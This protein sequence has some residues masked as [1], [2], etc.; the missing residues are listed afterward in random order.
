MAL[1]APKLDDRTFEQLVAEARARIPRYTPEWT[2]LNDAD[3]GMTLVKLQAWLTETI[4]WQLNRLPDLNY[5]KFLDL[6]HVQP[7]PAVAARTE[8]SFK[9]KKLSNPS[10]PLVVLVP[11]R[12]QVA[13]D[14]PDLT[15]ELV[16]ETDETLTA[17]NAALAAIVVPGED[18][19][20]RLATQYD[21]KKGETAIPNA[22]FPFG[23]QPDAGAACY[24]GFVLRPQRQD[25]V[26]YSLDRFPA[27]QLDLAVVLPRTGEPDARG[28]MLPG[29]EA[30]RCLFP[31]QVQ[32]AANGIEWHGFA[33]SQPDSQFL[34]AIDSEAWSKLD[35]TDETAA[36][37]RNG[38]IYLNAPVGLTLVTLVQLNRSF[39]ARLGLRKRP[40]NK[41]EL[42]EDLEDFLDPK[43]ISEA[44]WQALGVP[45]PDLEDVTV[46]LD[47]IRAEHQ[48]IDFNALTEER[49]QKAGYDAAPV[50][51]PM[52][53]FRARLTAKPGESPQVRRIVINT[54]AAT[55]AVTRV[56]EVVGDSD[57][58]PNQLMVLRRTPVLV[59]PATGK[60]T[61]TLV[62]KAP[63]ALGEI[64]DWTPV[65]D[66]FRQDAE[67]A[68]Y[69]LDPQTGAI[70]FGDGKHGQ[71]PVAGRQVIARSYRIGGGAIGNVGPGTVS[72]LKSAVREVDSV[73]NLEAAAGGQDAE[74]LSDVMLRAPHDLRARDRA[75]SAE[76]FGDLARQ[77]PGVP[78]QRAYA[79][80]ETRLDMTTDPTTYVPD[81]AGAVTVVILPDSKSDKPDPSPEQLDLVCAHLN[82]RR[83]ITTELYVTGPRYR[84][85]ASIDAEL[86]VSRQ[87]DLKA[88]KDGVEARLLAYFHPLRG[89]EDGRGWPFNQDAYFGNVYRHLLQAPGLLS[90]QC[91][92]MTPAWNR[93]VE[94]EPNAPCEDVLPIGENDLFYLHKDAIHLKVSY[95]DGR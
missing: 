93:D 89:G 34:E 22:F 72:K 43:L 4:L 15:Q 42:I 65:G 59:D 70:T 68:V 33:G 13:V 39:W 29:P 53:W 67:Q 14:D 49:W 91:L 12:T 6:L 45:H 62:V 9:L 36:L 40:Y 66:F 48:Q 52:T 41:G 32:Q 25:G 77:T 50:G 69:V 47:Q 73:T 83:L 1:P 92:T 61:L 10:D 95:D 75:V 37:T 8:L 54:I 38:H 26:D 85:I 24:L 7:R 30:L 81:S 90:V 27:E 17:L 84:T 63:G 19:K 31:W 80:A 58:R 21:E 23:E 76:D 28:V 5:V 57:G 2:N 94:E 71:I 46:L 51:L 20:L 60:S 78:I 74:P 79:L 86:L 82:A 35:E 56:D 64:E 87:A 18:G 11:Q 16:F 55:A 44:D 3:P 88:V